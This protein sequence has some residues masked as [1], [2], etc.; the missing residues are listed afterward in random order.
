MSV[1]MISQHPNAIFLF[2]LAL[3]KGFEEDQ[4]LKTQLVDYKRILMDIFI[5]TLRYCRVSPGPR[6]ARR[7]ASTGR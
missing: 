3:K 7:L 4:V 5:S 2:L 6:A 1:N